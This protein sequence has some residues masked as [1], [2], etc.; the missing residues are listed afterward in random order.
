MMGGSLMKRLGLWVALSVVALVIGCSQTGSSSAKKGPAPSSSSAKSALEDV[1]KTGQ[2]TSGTQAVGNYIN[3][4]R[5]TDSAKAEALD[6]DF[7]EMGKL[8][9]DAMKAKAKAIGDKL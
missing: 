5:A 8:T 6:K 4:L 2:M 9:G 3:S 1:A 7:K